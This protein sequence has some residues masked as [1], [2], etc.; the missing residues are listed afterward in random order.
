[1]KVILGRSLNS[2]GE[3][4]YEGFKTNTVEGG[5]FLLGAIGNEQCFFANQLLDPLRVLAMSL[6][7]HDFAL[8]SGDNGC[9]TLQVMALHSLRSEEK[10]EGVIGRNQ[11]G[12][13]L[14]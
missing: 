13:G 4:K 9:L 10:R 3:R 5:L 8:C 14:P 11:S 6:Q 1:M 7:R 2:L 12:I